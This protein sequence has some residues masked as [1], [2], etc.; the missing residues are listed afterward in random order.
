MMSF[1]MARRTARMNPSVIREILKITERPGIISL[2]GGLPSPDTFPVEAM[3]EA[4]ARVLRDSPRE[5]LQYAA[6]EGFGPLREWVAGELRAHGMTVDASQVL[7]TTGSQQGLDLAGKVLIDPGSTVAVESPAR[8]R[9][10]PSVHAHLGPSELA[11]DRRHPADDPSGNQPSDLDTQ[12]FRTLHGPNHESIL[13]VSQRRIRL[14][15]DQKQTWL[16]LHILNDPFT[17][18]PIDMHIE[19]IQED[20]DPNATILDEAGLELLFD[21]NHFPVTRGE[22]ETWPLGNHTGWIAKEPRDKERQ[23]R[24]SDRRND[25]AQPSCQQCNANSRPD[26]GNS[27]FGKRDA[28]GTIRHRV[29]SGYSGK[30]SDP[31]IILI[32]PAWPRGNSAHP[33]QDRND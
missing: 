19:D 7:I 17:G 8:S 22:D 11:R 32:S 6:S 31:T 1:Q 18:N 27:L 20:A 15:G 16:V 9:V 30:M 23:D 4:C 26:E 14:T 33:R 28:D 12:Y 10:C 25:P 13:L 24:C 5:A 2:A 21:R 3:R 29:A